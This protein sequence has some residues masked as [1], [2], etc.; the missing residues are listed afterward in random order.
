[1]SHERERPATPIDGH[2]LLAGGAIAGGVLLAGEFA[3]NVLVLQRSVE[4]S[5]R[6]FE[7]LFGRWTAALLAFNTLLLGGVIVFLYAATRDRLGAGLATKLGLALLVWFLAWLHCALV[8]TALGASSPGFFW[9]TAAW[10]LV[11]V[12]AAALAGTWVYERGRATRR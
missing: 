1:M 3:L 5:T 8:T 6:P 11:E 7:H 12:P 9:L 4:E 10:G 2:R